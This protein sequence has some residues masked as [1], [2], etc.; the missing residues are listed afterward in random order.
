[1]TGSERRP[2]V[3]VFDWD[4]TLVDSWPTIH[5]ALVATLKAMGHQP[6][7]FEETRTRVR[8]SLRDSF[9]ILFGDRWE[10]AR[11][12]FYDAFEQFH[13]DE[14]TPLDGAGEMLEGLHAL[15]IK[16]TVVSNKTG[17]YLRSEAAQLGW[18]RL[19]G[20]LVGAG[21]SVRDKP[22]P[23]A[24]MLALDGAAAP[25]PDVWFVGD[26][27]IDMEIAHRT[28][29]VPVLVNRMD[30]SAEEFSKWPPAHCFLDCP[31]LLDHVN[32]SQK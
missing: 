16:L 18:D 30:A 32:G 3:I 5:R 25:G 13:L 23:A 4:N 8:H 1:M 6:W 31:A 20:R 27:G 19:F 10:E 29:C 11:G 15:G 14:L 21:D 24:L 2:R 26:S 28:G 17:R 7:S 9:P 12:V 22:A